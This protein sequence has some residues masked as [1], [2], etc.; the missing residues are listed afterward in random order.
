MFTS[1]LPLPKP[2]ITSPESFSGKGASGP[3]SG[4]TVLGRDA[5]EGVDILGMLVEWI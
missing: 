1:L 3:L 4:P 2:L 5:R